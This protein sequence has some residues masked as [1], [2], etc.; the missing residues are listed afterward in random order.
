MAA[1]RPPNV[2]SYRLHKPSG[3]AV[4]TLNGRDHY[5]GVHG[6]EE[7]NTR[8]RRIVAE[9]LEHDGELPAGFD[10]G[11]YTVG[12]LCEEYTAHAR[13][14][15]RGPDGKETGTV[16]NVKRAMLSLFDLFAD[17][18]ASEFGPRALTTFRE[19]L[20]RADLARST[21]N[22]RVKLVRRAF[23]WATQEERIPPAIHQGLTTVPGLRRGR[24]GAREAAPVRPVPQAH[25]DAAL[26]HMPEPVRAMVQL[27]LL[28]G[29]RPGEI[30]G[31]RAVDI[32]RT[33]KVWVYTPPAH[34]NSWRGMERSIYLGPKAQAIVCAYLRPGMQERFLFSP[35]L[36]ERAR[37]ERL[38]AARVTPLY[39]SHVRA[40]KAK[41][42]VAPKRSP[43]DRYDVS[44]YRQAIVR[45]CKRAKVPEWRP[46]QLRHNAATRLRSEFGLEVAKAV[47]GHRLVETTQ[48]YAEA[49]RERA[50]EAIER[51]G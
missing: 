5:L 29:A 33:G 22:D 51:V 1:S 31:M 40:L 18:P 48:V 11:S 50:M 9:Y 7:S 17:L 27:Q 37:R 32:D 42:K 28:T 8:Y 35:T 3:Q 36:A 26:P 45:A 23:K 19:H 47:L 24:G 25:V 2:P 12:R 10:L 14:E 6:T 41:R 34:K 15:Y 46:N 16:E 49:D 39:P 44:S 4:V 20:V 21:I 30:V 13:R 43:R 38:R